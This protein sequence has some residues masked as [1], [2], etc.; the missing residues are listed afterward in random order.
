[1]A[2]FDIPLRFVKTP[3]WPT[4]EDPPCIQYVM[5]AYRPATGATIQPVLR[6]RMLVKPDV[7]LN[8]YRCKAVIDWIEIRLRTSSTHQAIN[9]RR[10]AVSA[11]GEIGSTSSIY[12]SG[13]Q[14]QTGYSGSEFNLRIQQPGPIALIY[15]C[16]KLNAKYRSTGESIGELQIAGIEVSI[17]FYVRK[18]D[19]LNLDAQNLLRWQMTDLLRRHLKPHAVLTE[20]EDCFPR[21]YSQA[22]GKR[23][24]VFVVDRRNSK[25]SGAQLSEVARLELSESVL[26]PLRLAAHQQAPVDTTSYIGSKIFPVMLRVM[27]KTTDRRDPK[28]NVVVI[29]PSTAWRSRVEVTLSALDG[30]YD[31]TSPVGLSTLGDLFRYQFKQIRKP[32]FEFFW[33][34]FNA[35]DD[36]AAFPFPTNISEQKV[37]ERSGVYGLDRLHRSM[38]LIARARF[39][40]KEIL[41]APTRLGSK[42]RLVSYDSLNRM[43]DRALSK[44]SKDWAR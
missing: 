43:M 5:S 12:V 20:Q 2:R 44:L 19:E 42:G 38:E 24:A 41:I 4:P 15:L 30:E 26:T 14:R 16:K 35:L 1:M 33:P 32:F 25:P 29:L 34:T 7:D 21:F 8:R 9:V 11:L 37:F 17:D 3:D 6:D 13:P 28:R 31:G 10:F 36:A 22:D 23:T 40:K 39:K 27:D 18:Q